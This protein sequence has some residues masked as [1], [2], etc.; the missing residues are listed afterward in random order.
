MFCPVGGQDMIDSTQQR[1]I[2]DV[3]EASHEVPV[4][5]DFW[6]PWCGPCRTLGPMLEK[7]ERAY[8]G[9]FRLVKVDSDQNPELS[10]TLGVRSIPYVIAFV[11]GKP[12]NAFVGALPESELRGFIDKVLPDPAEIQRL[13]AARLASL[14][15][16]AGAVSSLRAALALDPESDTARVDLARL[17]LDQAT[18]TGESKLLAEAAEVLAKVSRRMRDDPALASLR[19]RLGALERSAQLPARGELDARIAANATDLQARTDLA[20]RLLAERRFEEALEQ[21]AFVVE[22][23]RAFGDDAARRKMLAVFDMAG[24]QRELVSKFRRRL[25]A[26]LNR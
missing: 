22:H 20:D 26:A 5:V 17:L 13:K 21:L 25:A 3:V 11:G 12:V 6:A 1:F 18:A 9:R 14:G 7:L 24:D 16:I 23:D 15:D 19:T 2:A 10:A 8:E 4:V